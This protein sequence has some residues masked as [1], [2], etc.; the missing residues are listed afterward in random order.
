MS[1]SAALQ[2]GEEAPVE[3]G[4]EAE[5]PPARHAA[6]PP[7]KKGSKRAAR[8]PAALNVADYIQSTTV[9][10]PEALKIDSTV[11]HG[12]VLRPPTP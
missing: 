1:D 2:A 9:M 10:A 8:A 11:T 12:Q 6:P 7:P 3:A 4:A 5:A